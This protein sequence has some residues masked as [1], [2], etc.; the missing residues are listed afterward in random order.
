VLTIYRR[1]LRS[2]PHRTEGR[3]YRRCRCPLWVQGT[4]AG[5]IVRKSLDL[6]SWEA[7]SELVRMWEARGSLSGRIVAVPD[8][9]S[10]FMDDAR[11]RH[12]IY[13]RDCTLEHMLAGPVD[14]R[15]AFD[16][17]FDADI[18]MDRPLWNNDNR[19][20]YLD[21]TSDSQHIYALFSGR[22]LGDFLGG[23]QSLGD[24]LH[25][26]DWEGHYL[27]SWRLAEPVLRLQYGGNPSRLWG[28]R[29][30]P[31]PPSVNEYELPRIPR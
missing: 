28:L 9:V 7:A 12:L 11:A 17:R 13:S 22:R 6:S 26:F 14:V 18:G 24:Q 4:L 16:V 3:E 15:P 30:S 31:S 21:V 8:A 1:H 25:I 29:S 23:D 27:G 2:C 20:C 19:F 5:E 10:K